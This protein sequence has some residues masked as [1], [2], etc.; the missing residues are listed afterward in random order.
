MSVEKLTEEQ[1]EALLIDSN[2]SSLVKRALAII[3]AHEALAAK[4]RGTP[5]YGLALECESLEQEN[6]RLNSAM[7]SVRARYEDA[8]LHVSELCEQLE[9]AS[10]GLAAAKA[11]LVRCRAGF[12]WNQYANAEQNQLGRDLDAHLATQPSTETA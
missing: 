6:K 12:D 5:A 3:D 1:R 2:E 11:L 4:M 9:T 10:N 7:A 8:E